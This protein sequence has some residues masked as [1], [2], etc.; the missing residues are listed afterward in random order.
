MSSPAST[1]T[2]EDYRYRFLDPADTAMLFVDHQVGTMLFGISDLDPINL[3]NNT[4]MLAEGAKIFEL[5]VVLTT[6]NPTGV[7]GPLFSKL[8]ELFPD[9]PIIN[10]F[11]IN[12]WDDSEFVAAV[13]ATGCSR[14]I[15]AGVTANVCLTF[16]AV[17]AVRS[18]PAMTSTPSSTPPAA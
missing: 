8:T 7:N 2:R 5:P 12:A 15:I 9:Q 4:L 11:A 13:A 1:V 3:R 16:P 6:S 17:S 14:L 10:R 18:A